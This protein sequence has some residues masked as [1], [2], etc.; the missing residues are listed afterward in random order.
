MLKYHHILAGFF[1]Y[2]SCVSQNQ[3]VAGNPHTLT[4]GKIIPPKKNKNKKQTTKQKKNNN[5]N[6]NNKK[7]TT[8]TTA[9]KT[10]TQ[11]KITTSIP[12]QKTQTKQHKNQTKPTSLVL[13][14][15]KLASSL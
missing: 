6:N 1:A 5:N 10:N 7:T 2:L 11:N 13:N 8:T 14:V 9:R 12:P 15:L 3:N 4:E